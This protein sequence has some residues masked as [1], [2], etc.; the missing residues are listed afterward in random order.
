MVDNSMLQIAEAGDVPN[1]GTAKASTATSHL[2]E[3]F[4]GLPLYREFLST[5]HHPSYQEQLQ[6]KV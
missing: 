3:N 1:T 4:M 6:L 2:V 5:L